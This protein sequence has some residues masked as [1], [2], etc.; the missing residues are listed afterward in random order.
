LPAQ[1]AIPSDAVHRSGASPSASAATQAFAKGFLRSKDWDRH[2]DDVEQMANTPGFQALR[3][4]ILEL[5]RLSPSDRLL[6]IGS[7]TGLLAHAAAPHVARVI[8]LDESPAMCRH[9][10]GKFNRLDV[11]N[12]KV[13]Q[14]SATDLRLPDG[15]VDVIVSN[16]CFHNLSDVDKRRALAEAMRVLRP[17]GR[18]VFADMMFRISFTNRRDRSVITL[19]VKKLIRHGPAGLLRL[20]KNAGRMVA[21]R[22]EHPARVEWWQEALLGAGFVDVTVRALEHEGGIALARKPR[23]L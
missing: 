18:L 7:G 16:Y 11:T 9:L 14:N 19:V 8:A 3:D 5:A 4:L 1:T 17:N 12:A 21:G 20:L 15:A 10:E 2:V 6:D 22:G 23:A 13:L